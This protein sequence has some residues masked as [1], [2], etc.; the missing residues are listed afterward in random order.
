V[1]VVF[2]RILEI[3]H[4]PNFTV[5]P[6][7]AA[8]SGCHQKGQLG[9]LEIL[10]RRISELRKAARQCCWWAGDECAA[11]P[12]LPLPTLQRDYSIFPEEHCRCP[13]AVTKV[14]WSI[15]FEHPKGEDGS[16]FPRKQRDA[17][18]MQTARLPEV[19]R[20]RGM[21]AR[22]KLQLLTDRTSS[23]SGSFV[24]FLLC[25]RGVN[26]CKVKIKKDLCKRRSAG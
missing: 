17:V 2:V 11:S 23:D 7:C 12:R 22:C 1:T 20:A 6:P 21:R 8:E 19:Q 13:G 18:R 14:L 16:A 26:E 4:T 24:S 25:L 3:L 9:S 10:G 15:P 5:V